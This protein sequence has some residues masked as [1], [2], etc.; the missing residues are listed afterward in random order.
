MPDDV[1]TSKNVI[2]ADEQ[3]SRIVSAMN[4]VHPDIAD[5][6]MPI[7]DKAIFPVA[8][9][10]IESQEFLQSPEI[11]HKALMLSGQESELNLNPK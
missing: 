3:E 1:I 11:R 9:S 5:N 2:F 8:A 10:V 7:K 4:K 6:S